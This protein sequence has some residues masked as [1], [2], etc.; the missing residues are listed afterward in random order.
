MAVM[1]LYNEVDTLT[2]QDVMA[3]TQLP[4]KELIKQLQALVETK[5]IIVEVRVVKEIRIIT[6][7]CIEERVA[8]ENRIISS[9]FF[10]L[11]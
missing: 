5:I 3:G 9:D 8:K 2:F 4:E 1:L 11:T 7:V 6:L 10:I